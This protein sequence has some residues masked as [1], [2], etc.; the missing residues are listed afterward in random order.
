MTSLAIFASG[1]GSNAEN[2]AH[3]LE[4]RTDIKVKFVIYNRRE[5][6]VVDRMKRLKVPT[7]YF[8]NSD[9][10]E[11][12]VLDFLQEE[13]VDFI[14]L[15]GFL[16]KIPGNIVSNYPEKILNIHPA[17]LPKYGGKGMYGEHVHRAVKAAGEKE[18]GIT[19][20]LVNEFYDEGAI[21][22][23][24]KTSIESSDEAS[25]IASKIH[26]LEYEYFPR[27]IVDYILSNGQKE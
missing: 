6:G 18:S 19:I 27:T 9:L 20:H 3:Y 7:Y 22:F 5:A 13:K 17:L 2:I 24:A 21:V 25:D 23:Q 10:R 16:A 12:R 1:S 8:S 15:A 4:N 14:I 11:G 26:D